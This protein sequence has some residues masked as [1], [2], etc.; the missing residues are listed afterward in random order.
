MN[1]RETQFSFT[2][3]GPITTRRAKNRIPISLNVVGLVALL[4]SLC[5]A[6]AQAPVITSFSQNGEL[7][8]SNLMA[9]SVAS[10]EWA[11]SLAGPWQTNWTGLDA[12]SV[13]ASGTINVSVPMYYRVRGIAQSTTP[14]APFVTTGS[15]TSLAGTSATLNAIGN[16]NLAATTG[17]FRY[18]TTDPGTAND[19][20]GTRAPSIGG[21]TLGAGSSAVAYSRAITGLLPEMT[22]YYC[23]IADNAYGTSF[24]PILSFKTN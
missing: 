18:S 2:R 16:P 12:V 8:C 14:T 9:G 4:A 19:S 13:A 15:A 23:A 6:P 10:V 1:E 5:T 20:F 22:Y 21:S 24:G 17:W 11:S 7:V 3:V